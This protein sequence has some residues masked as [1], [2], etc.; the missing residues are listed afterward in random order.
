MGIKSFIIII[1]NFAAREEALKL[2]TLDLLKNIRVVTQN[3]RKIG[4]PDEKPLRHFGHKA[5]SGGKK[6]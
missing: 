3:C 4:N 5:L 1:F 6:P 2:A